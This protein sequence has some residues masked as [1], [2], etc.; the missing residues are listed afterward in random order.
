MTA[1][2]ITHLGDFRAA[3]AAGGWSQ[4]AARC[5]D[6]RHEWQ[7]V[8]PAGTLWLDCPACTLTRG[9]FVGQHEWSGPHWHC[10]CGND[11]FY[12]RED[13]FYCPNCGTTQ[14]MA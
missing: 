10:N 6:C 8:A 2:R 7:A 3:K 11:L 4:G 14:V 9:R 13:D 12:V 1:P 5:L